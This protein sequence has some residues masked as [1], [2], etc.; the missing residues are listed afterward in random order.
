MTLLN[1]DP[2]SPKAWQGDMPVSN[3]YTFGIAGERFFRA[4]KDEGR[5]LGTLCANCEHTYVP[6]ALFCEKCLDK[7]DDWVDVGTI[8]EVVT[9]THLYIDIH[10]SFLEE[11]ETIAFI[12]FGDGGLI[13]KLV[14]DD[15]S[16]LAIGMKAEAIFKPIEDREGSILD[17]KH[18]RVVSE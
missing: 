3:R 15:P 16:N 5:I 10:N 14:A 9:F 7:T 17:I 12:K 8:G 6:A 13:H 4:I 1:R 18:F 11:P 2:F